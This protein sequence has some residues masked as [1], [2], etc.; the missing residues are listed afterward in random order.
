[1]ANCTSTGDGAKAVIAGTVNKIDPRHGGKSRKK[2]RI[3]LTSIG[4]TEEKVR[5]RVN[6]E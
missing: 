3:H 1:M 4:K 6:E 5:K 2:I